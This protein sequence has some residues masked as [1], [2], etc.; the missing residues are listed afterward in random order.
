MQLGADST[1]GEIIA[2]AADAAAAAGAERTELTGFLVE[3]GIFASVAGNLVEWLL[4]DARKTVAEACR[5][6]S[7]AHSACGSRPTDKTQRCES[8]RGHATTLMT[9]IS[10]V[11]P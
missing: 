6:W 2:T 10:S 5:A 7:A 11:C 9:P 3:H 1:G 4:A 8:T